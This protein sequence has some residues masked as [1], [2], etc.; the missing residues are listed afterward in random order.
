MEPEVVAFLK[1]VALSIFLTFC[2]LAFNV[3]I[4][5]RFD[6]AFPNG[7]V[8]PGNILFYVWMTASFILLL[9]Y[10]IYLWKKSEK[11]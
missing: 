10:L 2:W 3:A 1:R 4:G 7:S 5:L 11:W 6:L 9:V 8:S